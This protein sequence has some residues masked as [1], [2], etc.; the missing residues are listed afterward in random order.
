MAKEKK[1]SYYRNHRVE[2]VIKHKAVHSRVTVE[3]YEIIREAAAKKNISISYFVY[4]PVIK[5]ARK[6]LREKE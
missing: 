4:G 5:E 6:V 3:E 1:Q 2:G